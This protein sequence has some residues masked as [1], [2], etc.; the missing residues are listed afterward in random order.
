MDDMSSMTELSAVPVRAGLEEIFSSG[1]RLRVAK[2][3]GGNPAAEFTGR[4]IAGELG[5]SHSTVQQA[6]R[7]LVD[8][9]FAFQRVI[10]KAY[11]FRA[12]KDSYLY[13]TVRQIIQAERGFNREIVN[14]LRSSFRRV[15]L[16]VVVFGSYARGTA[17]RDSDLDL[18]V[19]ARNPARVESRL[20]HLVTDFLRRYGVYVSTKVL[21]V[22]EFRSKAL[23]PYIRA[24]RREGI[25]V[26]GK[27]L[28]EVLQP[29]GQAS[30]GP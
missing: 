12:N 3:L 14:A 9:G 21:S 20:G 26:A 10:G 6:M 30:V 16:S 1:T 7:V 4:Q 17:R 24:A 19:V 22:K 29:A 25:L 11:V 2:L 23:V 28:E 8:N 27:P 13:R 18:L 5:I 15:A